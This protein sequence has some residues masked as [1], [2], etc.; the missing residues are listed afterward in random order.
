MLFPNDE[1]HLNFAATPGDK[2]CKQLAKDD[3]LQPVPKVDLLQA[4][5]ESFV[6]G[7][8]ILTTE[9]QLIHTNEFA[10]SICRQLMPEETASNAVPEEIWRVCQSLIESRELFPDE[11]IIIESEIEPKPT[12]KF[13]LRARWLQLCASKHNFLLVTVE[14]CNQYS[15]S[16]AIADAKKYNLTDREIEVWQLRRA[17]LSYREIANQLYITINTVK[18]HLKNIYA[19][20][21]EKNNMNEYKFA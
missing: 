14:D 3:N 21:Q 2:F 20:Q 8:F 1:N 11:K 12:V 4:I 16:I 7:I 18:K 5:I 19:K 13:R 10:R 9:G 17:N 15:Q 6:D